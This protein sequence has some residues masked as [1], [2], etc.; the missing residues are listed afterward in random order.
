MEGGDYALDGRFGHIPDEEMVDLARGGHRA[1]AEFLVARYR[2]LVECKA[3]DFYVVG[4]DREDVVQE[5]MIGLCKA[6]RDFRIDRLA[7]FRPF[8]ELCVTRQI[9]TAVKTATRQKHVPLN[10]SLSLQHARGDVSAGSLLPEG[11]PEVMLIDG[12]LPGLTI[13]L[14]LVE[15]IGDCLSELEHGVLRCYLAGLTYR[16]TS[17]ELGCH[18]KAIDNALQ[19]VRRK[20]VQVLRN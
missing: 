19:R 14:N 5:G 6:I 3:R 13:P 8:A 4:A 18:R 15:T 1:A 17:Q 9:I 2:P 20:V 12:S 16:E 11:K 7:K 10:G